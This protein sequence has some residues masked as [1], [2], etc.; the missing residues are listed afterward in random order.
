M[1]WK[2]LTPFPPPQ[3]VGPQTGKPWE[4][5]PLPPRPPRTQSAGGVVIDSGGHV[6]LRQPAGFFGG[7]HWNFPKGGVDEGENEVKAAQREVWEETGWQARAAVR[8]PINFKGS[9]TCT[10]YYLMV[11]VKRDFKIRK[12]IRQGEPGWESQAI[13]WASPQQAVKL[14]RQNPS[15][16]QLRDM[17]VL[18]LAMAEWHKHRARLQKFYH[19]Y[20]T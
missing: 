19:K 17:T 1:S 8:L 14:L 10:R 4:G 5:G 2:N 15:H 9:V 7:Y 20:G 13:R 12:G 3:S 11:P 6:L 16:R 18:A